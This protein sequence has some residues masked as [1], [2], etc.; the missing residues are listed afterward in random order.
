MSAFVCTLC[1]N[2]VKNPYDRFRVR[3]EV[4]RLDGKERPYVTTLR[5]VGRCCV[6]RVR[7]D[8]EAQETL[9]L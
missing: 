4:V 9:P 1:N 8:P 2:E 7:A 6:D 3:L 5:L